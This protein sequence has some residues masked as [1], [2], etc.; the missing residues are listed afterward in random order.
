MPRYIYIGADDAPHAPRFLGR[1]AWRFVDAPEPTTAWRGMGEVFA[2][3]RLCVA[4]AN[5]LARSGGQTRT[6]AGPTVIRPSC[7]DPHSPTRVAGPAVADA[8]KLDTN[9]SSIPRMRT[10]TDI[11]RLGSAGSG[12]R[13]SLSQRSIA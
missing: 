10:Y 4:V 6:H 11:S 12:A 13:R 2:R 8:A 1:R 7:A 9:R 3:V 5:T